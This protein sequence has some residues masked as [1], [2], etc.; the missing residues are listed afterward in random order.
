MSPVTGKSKLAATIAEANK[1]LQADTTS[2]GSPIEDALT[3]L[4]NSFLP[5]TEEEVK[6]AWT[7]GGVAPELAITRGAAL[8]KTRQ[9]LRRHEESLRDELTKSL[10]EALDKKSITHSEYIDKFNKGSASIENYLKESY[11]AAKAIPKNAWSYIHSLGD[12]NKLASR[13]NQGARDII[14]KSY[15]N[16]GTR[17]HIL[18][19]SPIRK[20]KGGLTRYRTDMS[21]EDVSTASIPHEAVHELDLGMDSALKS[22]GFNIDKYDREL[23]LVNWR[24]VLTN[25]FNTNIKDRS[26][27]IAETGARYLM[28]DRE[29]MDTISQLGL[30]GFADDLISTIKQVPSRKNLLKQMNLD[31]PY[32]GLEKEFAEYGELLKGDNLTKLLDYRDKLA[33]KTGLSKQDVDAIYSKYR[34][35]LRESSISL[36]DKLDV[37][38][39][40]RT[41]KWL[42]D[43]K[44][45]F[46]SNL[47]KEKSEIYNKAD[48]Y[49]KNNIN[50]DNKWARTLR[51]EIGIVSMEHGLSPSVLWNLVH[52]KGLTKVK[53]G[54]KYKTI[55]TYGETLNKATGRE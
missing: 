29:Y 27:L 46:L 39:K 54:D 10:N 8:N 17:A 23:T 21:I 20:L 7:S 12:L 37:K 25:K 4:Y 19:S 53:V 24:R 6:D 16:T 14:P 40:A 47:E 55:T 18:P 43:N 45:S 13:I 35:D 52:R 48:Y 49:T 44:E 30:S 22:M 33:A 15:E 3:S 1:P 51:N 9:L 42:T 28:G 41:S 50:M 32:K 36:R 26:E 5:S 38:V 31:S 2:Y 11:A 34:D